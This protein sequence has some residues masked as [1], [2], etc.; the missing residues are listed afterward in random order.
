MKDTL[1]V[2]MG[3]FGC[4]KLLAMKSCV[5]RLICTRVWGEWLCV[6]I[7]TYFKENFKFL[8][9]SKIVTKLIFY[10]FLVSQNL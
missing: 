3:K 2:A 9:G 7:A 4:S 5:G 1:G 10:N 6:L 8:K